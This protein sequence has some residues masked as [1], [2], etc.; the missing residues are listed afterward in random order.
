LI[1]NL[2]ERQARRAAFG[3]LF[4]TNPQS[5]AQKLHLATMMQP[6]GEAGGRQSAASITS[7]TS[8]EIKDASV[9]SGGKSWTLLTKAKGRVEKAAHSTDAP[10][11]WLNELPAFSFGFRRKVK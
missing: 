1:Q 2:P 9:G 11:D 4:Q 7:G 10:T 5:A 3:F 8:C 6:R